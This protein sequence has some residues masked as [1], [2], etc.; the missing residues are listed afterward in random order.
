MWWKA[1]RVV[2]LVMAFEVKFFFT[3]IAT[4]SHRALQAK[5]MPAGAIKHYKIT[6]H[7]TKYHFDEGRPNRPKTH[8][9]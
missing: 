5:T 9:G 3:E 6:E 2:W 4:T 7:S 1:M 8:H